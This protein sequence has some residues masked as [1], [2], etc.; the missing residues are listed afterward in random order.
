L[1]PTRIGA[2]KG[3]LGGRRGNKARTTVQGAGWD[4]KNVRW[5]WECEESG[6]AQR[7]LYHL[8]EKPRYNIGHSKN[9]GE[10]RKGEKKVTVNDR[11]RENRL[12]KKKQLM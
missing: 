6:G 11:G 10:R 1:V 9:W 5:V 4:K 7:R 2:K 8:G 3:G 12:E